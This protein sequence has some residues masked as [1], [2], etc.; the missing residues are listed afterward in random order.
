LTTKM[1]NCDQFWEQNFDSKW[2]LFLDL[3]E[4]TKLE[5][6]TLQSQIQS[7]AQ[8]PIGFLSNTNNFPVI[9]LLWIQCCFSGLCL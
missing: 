7:L 9:T 5:R 4:T 2:F 3:L 6:D 1:M 8:V